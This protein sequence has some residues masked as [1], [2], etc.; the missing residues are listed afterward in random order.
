MLLEVPQKNLQCRLQKS[1]SVN[2]MVRFDTLYM[3][4]LTQLHCI[5]LP[6]MASLKRGIVQS[7]DGSCDIQSV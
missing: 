2:K 7:S 5:H 6:G 3:L 1:I 4:C